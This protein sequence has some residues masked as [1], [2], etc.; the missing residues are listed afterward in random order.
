MASYEA[1]RPVPLSAVSPEGWLRGYLE[2][3]RDGLTGRKE[4]SGYPFDTR[5]W[6]APVVCRRGG[7]GDDWWPYEQTAYWVDGA[8]RCGLLLSDESLT[9]AAS[10][11]I[12]YVVSH[13]MESG[14]FG[15]SHLASGGRNSLWPHAVFSRALMARANAQ[16]RDD[17]VITAL[18]GFASYLAGSNRLERDTS[19]EDVFGLGARDVLNLE[20]MLFAAE[21][22]AD[23]GLRD[24]ALRLFPFDPADFST[25][26]EDVPSGHGV[27]YMENLKLP[28]L[29]YLHS[30][31][32]RAMAFARSRYAALDR[33][34]M[35]IDGVPSACEDFAGRQTNAVHETCVISDYCWTTGYALRATGEVE[36]AD[37]IER[38]VLN[39]GIGC[40]NDEFT[41]HQYY[42]GPNQVMA[43]ATSSH[44]NANLGW[45][46]QSKPRMAY[47]PGHDTECCTGNLHRI[48]PNYC[49]HM[50]ARFPTPS[51]AFDGVAALVYGPCTLQCEVGPKKTPLTIFE[52]T[53]FPFDDSITFRF[54]LREP[55]TFPFRFR[56]PHWCVGPRVSVAGKPLGASPKAGEFAEV[57]RE[58][59]DGDEIQLILPSST[60]VERWPWS[61]AAVRRGPLVY[62]IPVA[63]EGTTREVLG[64]STKAFP[65]FDL[66]PASRWQY[67]I[68]LPYGAADADV[69][70]ETGRIGKRPWTVDGAPIRVSLPLAEVRHWDVE[71]GHTPV[72]P[73]PVETEGEQ[74]VQLVPLGATTLRMTLMPHVDRD[75]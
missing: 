70:V 23:S 75:S 69:R 6:A 55:A 62:S 72:L 51:G 37:R 2:G 74:S 65:A 1:L 47:Q 46:E 39:A 27:S 43:D 7:P 56:I 22:T 59:Q 24:A 52:E 48:M 36:F 63:S 57:E 42:S 18:A 54:Q 14:Y 12:D 19:R 17:R 40:V 29:F 41:A 60:E 44:W 35:L 68:A 25:G 53:E 13:Q 9:D 4:H 21:M 66:R 38:A 30:G 58:F 31:D 10:E 64:K 11:Q 33:H 67:A 20:G 34:H 28:I 32:D 15:P 49:A 45:F 8:L 5:G 16:P 26:S 73:S 71:R 50:W 3:Q 61:G